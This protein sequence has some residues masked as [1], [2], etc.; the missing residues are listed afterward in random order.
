MVDSTL[1]FWDLV[2]WTFAL[3]TD[4]LRNI[5]TLPE[6]IWIAAA[7]A[8]LAGLSQAIAQAVVLFINQV[9]P[10]R[11][12]LSLVVN[13]VLFAAG[14]FFLIASTWLITLLPW[15]EDIPFRTLATILGVSYVPLIF[16]FFGALPYLGVPILTLLSV[17]HLLAMVIGFSAV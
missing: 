12:V 9:K 8:L 3:S 4:A 1:K 11:F 16:S 13:G 5:A 2:G 10:L 15:S 17:W 14:S 7:V 6:G